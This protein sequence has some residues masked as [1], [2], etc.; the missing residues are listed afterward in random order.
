LNGKSILKI[1]E[2][3]SISFMN[4]IRRKYKGEKPN[5]GD[6]IEIQ[7]EQQMVFSGERYKD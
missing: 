3:E 4:K 6:K 1:S 7:C 2:N 5:I